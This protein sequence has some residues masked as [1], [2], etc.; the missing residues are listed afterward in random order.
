ENGTD[1]WGV[2][3]P[4]ITETKLGSAENDKPS[5]TVRN[6]GS[7]EVQET[8]ALPA[9]VTNIASLC[10][11][12][13]LVGQC[14]VNC[15]CDS[16]CNLSDFSL[17]SGCSVPVVT[18][19]SQLCTQETIQYSI[20]SGQRTVTAVENI[21]PS[22]FCIQTANYQPALFYITP[23]VPTANNFDNLLAT[24]SK[25]SFGSAMDV[26][27]TPQNIIKYEYGSLILTTNSYL[28]LP[29][30]LGTARCTDRNPVGF[31]VNQDSMCS[32]GMSF[33]SC[34][35]PVLSLRSYTDVKI[36]SSSHLLL[37]INITVQSI[38]MK[39]LSGIS[40]PNSVSDYVP[41][42]DNTT[43]I[44]NNVVLGGNYQIIYTEQG[45][46]L[47]VIAS[48]L[49][50]AVNTTAG[51]IQQNFKVHFTQNGTSPSPLSGNP[52]YVAGL[53]IVAGYKEP[54][55]GI[56]QNTNRF[57]QLTI[58]KSSADQNCL[59]QEGNR[60]AILFGYNMAS[61]CKLQYP[62]AC[63]IAAVSILNVLKGQQFPEYV[64]SFGNSQPQNFLDWVPI[65]IL[66]STLPQT[67][68][69]SCKIP[70][71][72]DLEVRW[73]KYGSLVN[74][75]AQIVNVTEKITYAFVPDTNLGSGNFLQIS[76]SVTFLDVSAPAV[77]GY[78]VP[79]TIDAKLPFD[80]FSPFV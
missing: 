35:N 22:I 10:V 15:C 76:T 65:T 18:V 32:L 33:R 34:S 47:D 7:S 54:Q 62:V 73:T 43:G 58:L 51:P 44:C 3:D 23:D 55:S 61:G 12:D 2:D 17:F 53:P 57:G 56:I 66:I 9:P 75:Q 60:A 27:S 30:P 5:L 36:L 71:S 69:A 6:T 48:F 29:A 78:K 14:D 68:T 21:N 49:L 41:T 40:I 63:Q 70:I 19:D 31:L 42:L 64:A 80:F 26:P 8:K 4:N 39:S 37:Q 77:P 28:T 11:C 50:G 1:S 20:T 67:S 38:S 46:I 59:T 52:G 13:L 79:P 25:S 16:D 74:P 72:F 24:H 45:T